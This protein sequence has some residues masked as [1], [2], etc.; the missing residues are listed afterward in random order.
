MYKATL[1]EP[2]LFGWPYSSS[3]LLTFLFAQETAFEQLA[4]GLWIR[5][6]KPGLGSAGTYFD[7]EE[8]GNWE[9]EHRL[10]G[11]IDTSSSSS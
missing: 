4:K 6:S 9:L 11:N 7:R 1:Q 3:H 5:N 10:I 2:T 8:I